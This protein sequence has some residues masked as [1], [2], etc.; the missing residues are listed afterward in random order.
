[1][2]RLWRRTNEAAAPP[3]RPPLPGPPDGFAGDP[4]IARYL[5]I[6]CARLPRSMPSERAAE[7]RAELATHLEMLAE[8]HREL[9]A[10]AATAVQAAL[11]QFGSAEAVSRAWA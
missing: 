2:S 1:M 11:A 3:C 6:V 8:A 9:G 4:D 7:L 5:A 10:D